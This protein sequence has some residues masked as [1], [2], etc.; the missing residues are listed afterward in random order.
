MS[1]QKLALRSS[2]FEN[3]EIKIIDEECEIRLEKEPDFRDSVVFLDQHP[4]FPHCFTVEYFNPELIHGLEVS[5]YRS[6]EVFKL[7]EFCV[8]VRERGGDIWFLSD[9]SDLLRWVSDLS[10]DPEVELKSDFPNTYKGFL[11]FQIKGMNFFKGMRGG[12]ARWSTGAGKSVLAVGLTKWYLDQGY[13]Y[14]L[15]VLKPLNLINMQRKLEKEDIPST[16][17]K[18]TKREKLYQGLTQG[19]VIILNYEKLSTDK[20]HWKALLEGKKVMVFLDEP[21]GKLQTRDKALYRDFCEVFFTTF[22][23]IEKK[24]KTLRLYEP[25]DSTRPAT[26]NM[27]ALSA[28]PIKKDPSNWFNLVRLLDPSIYGTPRQFSRRFIAR[29]DRWGNPKIW[30]NEDLLYLMSNHIV[31]QVD[32][33]S[34]PDVA[35]LFPSVIVEDSILELH[36]KDQAIYDHLVQEYRKRLTDPDAESIVSDTE[37]LSAISCLYLLCSSSEAVLDSALTRAQCEDRLDEW[38]SAGAKGRPPTMEGSLV[39]LKLVEEL[40]PEKFMWKQGEIRSTKMLD[41]LDRV[42]KHEGKFVTFTRFNASM[43]PH[44][45]RIFTDHGISHVVLHGGM[46]NKQK[47]EAQDRFRADPSCK[48]FLSSD[49]GQDSIDLEVADLVIEFDEAQDYVGKVQRVNRAVRPTSRFHSVSHVTQI[50]A[51][52]VE[53]NNRAIWQRKKNFHDTH[54]GHLLGQMEA[55]SRSDLEY[56]IIGPE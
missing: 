17:I 29:R 20:E 27:L 16:I 55:L 8:G 25:S 13:D 41:L 54:S 46:T 26:L 11:P 37:L 47:Q 31:H 50:V 18:G 22:K 3:L 2:L 9:P 49:S 52:T 28:T 10:R 33:N 32:K 6:V 42:M 38:K 43:I 21:H 1:G 40:G 51:G 45:S 24:G 34:D 4:T 23:E 19:G 5:R 44:I 30:K 56:L 35:A 12:V 14:V 7:E 53:E 15:H 48:G 39:A 36:K